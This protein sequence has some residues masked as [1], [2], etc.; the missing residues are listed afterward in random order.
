MLELEHNI[1]GLPGAPDTA[2]LEAELREWSE[3]MLALMTAYSD[4]R[5]EPIPS[6]AREQLR[7]LGYLR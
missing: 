1:H 4:T 7:A 5:A 3:D 2:A 6:A